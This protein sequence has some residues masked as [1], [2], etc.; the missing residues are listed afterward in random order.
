MEKLMKQL[1]NRT[2][3]YLLELQ[4]PLAKLDAPKE[5]KAIKLDPKILDAYVGEYQV[6]PGFGLTVSREGDQLF[7]QAT[8]QNKFELFAETETDFFLKVVNAQ[9]TFIKDDK[10]QVTG[11]VLHQNGANQAAKKVK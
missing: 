10:G 5:R 8:G 6:V 11:L 3:V 7:A 1:I 2:A 4:Y 9:I